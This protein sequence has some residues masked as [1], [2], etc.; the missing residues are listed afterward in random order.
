MFREDF[1]INMQ[2]KGLNECRFMASPPGA[3]DE[4]LLHRAL[5]TSGRSIFIN[6]MN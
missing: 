1:T 3:A 4:R 2:S 6:L 5:N